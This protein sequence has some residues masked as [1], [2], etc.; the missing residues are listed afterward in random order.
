MYMYHVVFCIFIGIVTF[1]GHINIFSTL[2]KPN[3]AWPW[4]RFITI[5]F[6]NS[7]VPAPFALIE[8]SSNNQV[9]SINFYIIILF[10]VISIALSLFVMKV[11]MST[12]K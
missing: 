8:L 2:S 5:I 1:V 4:V 3:I 11:N 12:H 6:F 9:F 10:M 7:L